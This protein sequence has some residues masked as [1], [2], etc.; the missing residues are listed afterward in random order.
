MGVDAMTEEEF[1]E[2]FRTIENVRDS[3]GLGDEGRVRHLYDKWGKS[4]GMWD[5]SVLDEWAYEHAN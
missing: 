4:V 2:D 3:L 1:G 5:L